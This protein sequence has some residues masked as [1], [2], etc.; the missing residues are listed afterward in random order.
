MLSRKAL[1]PLLLVFGTTMAVPTIADAAQNAPGGHRANSGD[2]RRVTAQLRERLESVTEACID[3]RVADLGVAANKASGWWVSRPSP[4]PT[5]GGSD[6]LV[7]AMLAAS[8]R[9]DSNRAAL[10][11]VRLSTESF[12]WC[13]GPSSTTDDLMLL[14]LAGAT[15]WLR[16]HGES[17]EWP[18]ALDE[19]TSR[20]N[21]ALARKGRTD[22]GSRLKKAMVDLLAVSDHSKGGSRAAVAVLDLVDVLE[23]ALR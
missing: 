13:G 22:L 2:C 16:G 20:V 21:K 8:E 23:R 5:Y 3:G 18:A 6:S 10:A 14:D 12:A 19:V 4:W 11:A 9:R 7:G 17:L 15:G 1:L